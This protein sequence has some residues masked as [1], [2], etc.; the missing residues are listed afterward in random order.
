[1][2]KL[3]LNYILLSALFVSPL[4]SIAG[5]QTY[6]PV[7][8]QTNVPVATVTGGGWTE[9]YSDLYNNPMVTDTVLSDC[10]GDQLMLACR[11][12]GSDTLTLLAQGNRSDVIF[13]TGDN[14]NVLHIANGVGWYFSEAHRS[15]GFV[16]AGDSVVKAPCDIDT[17][18]ANDERLCWHIVP[19][20][21]GGYRCGAVEKLNESTSFERIVYMPTLL[22]QDITLSPSS[23]TNDA[24][25]EHTVTATVLTNGAPDPGELVTFEIISGPNSGEMSDPNSG[26]CTQNDDCT[27]DANGQVSWTYTG[28]FPGTDTIVASFTDVAGVVI[29][30]EPVEKT[31]NSLPIP[32]LSEW[33]LIITVGLL[34]IMGLMV[35]RKRKLRV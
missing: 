5:A 9:C 6:L 33:G 32:T 1:M 35:I 4:A 3:I 22:S 28:E 16:R 31:W 29:E 10:P 18:G 24:G 14:D 17:S 7:G 13:D 19:N 21:Q 15:W 8:P 11:E 26:E 30:S 27:T 34:G 23:A 12:T 20:S 25:T 2:S